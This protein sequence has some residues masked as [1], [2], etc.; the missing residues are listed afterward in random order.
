MVAGRQSRETSSGNGSYAARK[1]IQ[2]RLSSRNNGRPRQRQAVSAAVQAESCVM[3]PEN[4]ESQVR[5]A[6]EIQTQVGAAVPIAGAGGRTQR[7]AS[8]CEKQAGTVAL[9]VIQPK[10]RQA[11]PGGR[12]ILFAVAVVV[13]PSMVQA[14]KQKRRV[15]VKDMF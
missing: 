11:G 1:V 12:K 3:Q 5:N 9:Q 4:A 7:T 13:K 6:N 2:E 10:P 8:V 14:E 15:V